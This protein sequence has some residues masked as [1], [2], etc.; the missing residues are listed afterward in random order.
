MSSEL[1]IEASESVEVAFDLRSCE[2]GEE[3]LS[4]GKC[5]K[6]DSGQYL[7]VA[8]LDNKPQM[9]KECPP[10]EKAVCD[11]GASIY[12][13]PGYW[14]S[15][16]ISD[17]FMECRNGDACLGRNGEENNTLGA[18]AK[19]YE[20]ILC[21][22]CAIGFSRTGSS[23]KCSKC[24]EEADNAVKITFMFIIVIAGVVFLVRSTL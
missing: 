3:L 13:Q 1:N 19:G 22:D 9:C 7:L 23:Y 14:R 11:G 21:A 18:C 15:S 8:P 5:R 4:S 2:P 12:P 16:N 10:K 24:P 6:C 17:N 20:G